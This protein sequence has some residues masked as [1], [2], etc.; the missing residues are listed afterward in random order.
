MVTLR[1]MIE[2]DS[3]KCSEI[4]AE[5]FADE[6]EMGMPVFSSEY[7]ASRI[8]SER[9]KII[10]ADADG[11]VGFMVV[12]DATVEAP[13]VLHLVAVD[14]SKRGQGIG[15]QLVKHAVD[16]TV[17]NRWSKLKLHT[18]PWNHAMRKVCTDLG[19]TQEA[20]LTKEYLNHDLIQYGYFP[21]P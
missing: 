2:T 5:A 6:I 7:F 11:V 12:T 20:H 17:E 16:Y 1:S 8:P 21:Q 9:V 4:A 10:V 14:K 18:R 15:K 13:A 3:V 19:F